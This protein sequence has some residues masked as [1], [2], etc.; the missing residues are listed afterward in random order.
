M[1]SVIVPVYNAEKYL[2]Q[3]LDSVL[4]QTLRNIEIICVDDGSTD[5]SPEILKKYKEKDTRIKLL[6]QQN[7]HAGVA[8]NA[9]LTVATG[10]YVHFLDADDWV[11]ENAYEI[12]VREIEKSKADV[13]VCFF[14]KFDNE[15]G[16]TQKVAHSLNSDKYR[17]VSNFKEN[18]RYFLYNAVVPWNKIYSREFLITNQIKFD[19]L[20]C[21]N[22]RAFY[23]HVL[24]C[25]AKIA[26]INE[27][28][29]HYRVNNNAS[30]VGETRIKNFDCHFRSFEN[31]WALV[32]D[33]NNEI[34]KMILDISLRDFFAFYHKASGDLKEIVEKQLV[35]YILTMPLELMENK[36]FQYPWGREY[37]ALLRKY[38]ALP[39][40]SQEET[41]STHYVFVPNAP[42]IISLTSF[43][44][45]INTVH[46][47]INTLLN[48]TF[49]ADKV[50]LW[51]AEEEFPNKEH[52]LPEK[53]L[54]LQNRGLEI[55]WC[56]NIRSYKKLIPT[57]KMFPDAII[58]TADDDNYYQPVWL[59]RMYQ[60]YIKQPDCIH[61]HRVTKF[62]V[63]DNGEFQIVSGGRDYYPIPSYLNKLVGAGG[64]LYPPHCFCMD[65]LDED[66]FMALAPTSDDIWFWLMA[67]LA[68]YRVNVVENNIVKLAYVEGTQ[69]GPCL[70]KINDHGEKLFFTHFHNMLKAYPQLRTRLLAAYYD[71]VDASRLD[72]T[73]ISNVS[74]ADLK[75]LQ[76]KY[77]LAIA[78]AQLAEREIGLIHRSWTYRSGRFIT[79]IPRMLRGLI[80]CY[81]EHGF[82]YT[83]DRILIHLRLRQERSFDTSSTNSSNNIINKDQ[84]QKGKPIEK[85]TIKRD[86]DYYRKLSPDKYEEELKIW[87]E[88]VMRKPLNLEEPE[89]FNEKIQWLKLYDSTPIKTRLA[90]K[91]LV[92]EWIKKKIGE[93]YL[94]PLLGVWN[95]FDDIDFDTLPQQF[96]LKANH[97]SGWNIIV[98]DKS[99]LNLNDAKEK[100]DTWM[101]K[102]FAFV[103]GL[104]L[105]YMNIP[106]K[107]IAE[108]YIADLDGD[109]YDYRFF[110]FNGVPQYVWVD[111]GSGTRHH[112]RNIYDLN[113]TI[114][115]YKVNYPNIV[116]SP[117]KPD[118]F[119][120]MVQCAKVLCEG[121]AFVRVDFYSVKNHVYFGEMTFTPQSGTG[122][123]DDEEQNKHYGE[124]IKLPEKSPIP[125]LERL[126][127]GT[128]E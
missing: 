23:I 112:K 5:Q 101:N 83:I 108:Q 15:T 114:Q 111:V 31:I 96:V 20:I 32:K 127:E 12:L 56:N 63:D 16:E 78:R 107:I 4:N 60:S 94:V 7:L 76:Q 19:D 115:N 25:A 2:P 61:C 118:T 22:D 117:Q 14:E 92:R 103:W 51:L 77:K 84:M 13:C 85:V 21:S 28:L 39:S 66:K 109:I 79:W 90:D 120:E 125:Q 10:K 97:A 82:N 110:C 119:E 89:T 17:C 8:R 11:E 33:E 50:L 43:P 104:E 80:R 27:Y 68:G 52:D 37:F 3:C 102:N 86:Y 24:L 91:Y 30:L 36:M 95:C 1:V 81:Q 62:I 42:I 128:N 54:Q 122:K 67:A 46:K 59:E 113:W 18:P 88:R 55:H 116:P 105:H 87:Y 123:W 74:N 106:P 34:K 9:G 38:S 99:S 65:V 53:L 6:S 26:I 45:R 49:P 75:L 121:F 29:I 124:L 73:N 64:V 47:T 98:R 40:V 35:D 58:V 71:Y 70:T 72:T 57:L 126:G 44:A 48:Q 69:D 100:F 93:Q 41:N